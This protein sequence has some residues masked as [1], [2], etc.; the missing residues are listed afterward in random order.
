MMRYNFAFRYVVFFIFSVLASTN[1]FGGKEGWVWRQSFDTEIEGNS[2]VLN[3]IHMGLA[4]EEFLLYEKLDDRRAGRSCDSNVLLASLSLLVSDSTGI[5][6][7][8]LP[9]Y[10][11]EDEDGG[12]GSS[13]T[14]SHRRPLVFL[15]ERS[16]RKDTLKPLIAEDDHTRGY[17]IPAPVH[18]EKLFPFIQLRLFIPG[19]V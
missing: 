3:R 12:A 4:R 16:F 7:E 13:A 6:V 17:N 18:M 15:S 10:A 1:V 11:T 9:I 2:L 19:N 5:H 8:T 14:T